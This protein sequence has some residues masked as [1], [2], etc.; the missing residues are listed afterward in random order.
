MATKQLE[1]HQNI[2]YDVVAGFGSEWKKFD[3]SKASELEQL[4]LFQ[5]YFSLFPWDLLPKDAVGFDVGCGTGRWARFVAARVGELHCIDP[6]A[7]LEVAQKNLNA[8]PNCRFHK[9]S[10]DDIPMQDCSA[11]FGY[12]LGVLHHL[13][14][15]EAGLAACVKKL[16]PGAPFLV[17]VY[18]A[19]DNKPW[20]F[21]SIWKCT[22]VGREAIARL[23]FGFRSTISEVIA[24]TVYWP[25]A[26]F[27]ALLESAGFDVGHIPL[28]TYR[29]RSLYA[30][31]NDALDRFG[32]KLEARFTRA[33]LEQMM[34][35]AG[36]EDI[37]FRED[38][39]YW[40]AVGSKRNE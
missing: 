24:M 2:D 4:D 23:P 37:R 16:K 13:P 3:Y 34:C 28:S 6:S 33:E 30:M 15:P 14:K 20:W 1:H 39:P 22:D 8:F 36:L 26:K 27:A 18:Y 9:S 21:R 11:D 25:L 7:A 12:A 40:C 29:H 5:R 17:Y 38:W 19:F 10:T 32:T 35:R 31:R